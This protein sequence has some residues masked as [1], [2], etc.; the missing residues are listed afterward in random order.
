[1]FPSDVSFARIATTTVNENEGETTVA[2][3]GRSFL[4]DFASGQYVLLDGGVRECSPTEA[5][6]QWI[7]L[8]INT[9]ADKYRIYPANYGV[10]TRGLIGYRLPRSF[11]VSEIKRRVTAGILKYC[12]MVKEVKNWEFNKG[13]FTLTVVT[14]LGEELNITD[15]I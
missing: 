4:F 1:M 6:C 13:I 12:P 3:V 2:T 10:D 15:D 7:K 5:I 9:E 11:I 14:E 8:Y